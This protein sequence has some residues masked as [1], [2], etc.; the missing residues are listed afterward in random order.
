MFHCCIS[1][2][3]ILFIAFDELEAMQLHLV[4]QII[5]SRRDSLFS[6]YEPAWN[7]L[8]YHNIL[9]IVIII[10]C[11]YSIWRSRLF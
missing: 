3:R 11:Y 4:Q 5:L 2:N 10:I 9:H 6:Y 1:C 7:R 8:H